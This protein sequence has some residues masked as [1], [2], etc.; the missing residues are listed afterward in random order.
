MAKRRESKK[1][2]DREK[3]E[4]N[5]QEI[6]NHLRKV[7]AWDPEL[8]KYLFPM[9]NRKD[10]NDKLLSQIVPGHEEPARQDYPTGRD[11]IKIKS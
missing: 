6:K 8:L 7:W 1:L 5:P 10:K 11:K 9:L 3:T 2:G 4:L